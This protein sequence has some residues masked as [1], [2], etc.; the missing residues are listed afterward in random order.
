MYSEGSKEGHFHEA[1]TAQSAD[2]A[3]MAAQKAV[4]TQDK[5]SSWHLRGYKPIDNRLDVGNS[6]YLGEY[7]GH[8]GNTGW[9]YDSHLPFDQTDRFSSGAYNRFMGGTTNYSHGT[10]GSNLPNS[11]PTM[12]QTGTATTQ[13]NQNNVMYQS[14]VQNSS[15]S[16]TTATQTLSST[17]EM[18]MNIEDIA[19]H[20]VYRY[21]S[22]LH[23]NPGGLYN[24]YSR[25][26]QLC[27]PDVHG[28]RTVANGHTEIRNYYA[29][30]LPKQTT[31]NIKQI[32]VQNI[33]NQ[34]SLVL[35]I[36]GDV[37]TRIGNR[38]IT[39]R[40]SHTVILAGDQTRSRF[41]IVNDIE[42]KEQLASG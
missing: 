17:P 1:M 21:Y 38:V 3:R 16:Q 18:H 26:A 20:F 6:L 41:H 12:L 25:T 28:N 33:S 2:K 23:S 10:Y 24:L 22:L 42:L 34:G 13:S 9:S 5:G 4:L 7:Q 35:L 15:V 27:K 14:I 40:V 32:E 30:F 37:N 19:H 11:N 31:A 39:K 29:Q 8:S 36:V